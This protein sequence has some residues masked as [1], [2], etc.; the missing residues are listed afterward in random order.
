[1]MSGSYTPE[2]AAAIQ[3]AFAT[4]AD[5]PLWGNLSAFQNDRVHFTGPHWLAN[6]IIEAHIVLDETFRFFAGVDPAEV[7]PNPFLP[8]EAGAT[9][10]ATPSN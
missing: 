10:E 9:P 1:M 6:G 7:S 8:T 4:L 5:D 3:T 2:Q